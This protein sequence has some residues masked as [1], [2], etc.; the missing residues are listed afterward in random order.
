M[1]NHIRQQI[2]EQIGTTLTGLTT[3]GSN[4][5]QSRVYPLENSK[6]PALII[7]TRSESIEPLDMGSNRTLQRNLQLVI[8]AFAKGTSN[9]DD[10]ADTIA[11]EIEIAMAN[12]TTHNDLAIDSFL[13]TTEIEYNGEGDQPV[14]SLSMVY[15]ITYIT[16]ENAPDVAL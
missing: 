12:D 5:Y 15:N 1:A 7:Y 8:E 16:T 13:E 3:T 2:R 14:A 10:T 6:L 9:T 11:K 4:V